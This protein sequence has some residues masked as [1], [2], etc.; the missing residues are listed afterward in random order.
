MANHLYLH[1]DLHEES[2][3]FGENHLQEAYCR[4]YEGDIAFFESVIGNN[5]MEQLLKNSD[6]VKYTIHSRIL[7][8]SNYSD[9]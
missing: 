3:S 4:A 1:M 2:N 7:T 5:F 9:S 6:K 8:F